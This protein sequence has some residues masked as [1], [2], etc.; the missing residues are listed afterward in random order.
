LERIGKQ[1][2]AETIVDR[3]ALDR[4]AFKT[5]YGGFVRLNRTFN[6]ELLAVL[7]SINEEIWQD[8]G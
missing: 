8:M 4:G 7:E 6:G 1:L 3:E 5:E 2:K